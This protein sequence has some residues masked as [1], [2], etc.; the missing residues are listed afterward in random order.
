MFTI[1]VD[2]SIIIIII[3]ISSSSS[4][5]SGSSS[6]QQQRLIQ[7]DGVCPLL[8]AP[9]IRKYSFKCKMKYC[10]KGQWRLNSDT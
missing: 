10:M 8:P 9:S 6:S 4:S 7:T 5:S 1:T 2:G 3:I